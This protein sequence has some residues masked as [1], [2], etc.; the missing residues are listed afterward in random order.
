[1]GY[2]AIDSE[3]PTVSGRV[4]LID[5][6]RLIAHEA[7][8]PWSR[9]GFMVCAGRR[10]RAIGAAPGYSRSFIDLFGCRLRH[11]VMTFCDTPSGRVR[12][13]V[14]IRRGV[15][16]DTP[17]HRQVVHHGP[18]IRSDVHGDP[19]VSGH[20]QAELAELGQILLSVAL[21]FAGDGCDGGRRHIGAFAALAGMDGDSYERRQQMRGHVGRVVQ[22]PEQRVSAHPSARHRGPSAPSVSMAIAH[23]PSAGVMS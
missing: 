3:L 4:H 13:P 10:R 17:W 12:H 15:A 6:E 22:R 9:P 18:T 7:P 14:T 8:H 19:L 5:S 2:L 16:C 20:Q 1:M 23:E 11:P 21:G